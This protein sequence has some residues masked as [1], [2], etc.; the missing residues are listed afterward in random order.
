MKIFFFDAVD[1]DKNWSSEYIN[2]ARSIRAADP[3]GAKVGADETTR[4][5]ASCP[6]KSAT[7]HAPNTI[8]WDVAGTFFDR[9]PLYF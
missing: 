5:A 3:G 9:F 1:F 4:T 2:S 7:G 8:F 6:A